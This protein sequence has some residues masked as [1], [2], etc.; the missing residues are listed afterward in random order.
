MPNPSKVINKP[1]IRR[2]SGCYTRFLDLDFMSCKALRTFDLNELRFS[3]ASISFSSARLN[4]FITTH[5]ENANNKPGVRKKVKFR[6]PSLRIQ[7]IGMLGKSFCPS[8]TL[9]SFGHYIIS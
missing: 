5:F 7:G 9:P 8:M 2:N 1:Y 6:Q 3:K 4:Q